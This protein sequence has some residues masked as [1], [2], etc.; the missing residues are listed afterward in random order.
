[1]GGVHLY[2]S[3]PMVHS[4]DRFVLRGGRQTITLGNPRGGIFVELVIRTTEV[5]DL[6]VHSIRMLS[7]QVLLNEARVAQFSSGDADFD[8]AWD[9]SLHT[10]ESGTDDAYSDCPWRERGTYI[11]DC[12]VNLHLHEQVSADFSLARR[13]FQMFGEGQHEDGELKGTLPSVVPAW[14]RDGHEDFTFIWVIGLRDYWTH[15]G[16][17]SL[18][19]EMWDRVLRLWESPAWLMNSKGLLDLS[20]GRHSRCF[21]DW[22][23]DGKQ[24]EGKS[25]LPAN[26]FRLEALKATAQMA[27]LLQ[28][29]DLAELYA[30]QAKAASETLLRVLWNE[31][32]GRFNQAENDASLPIHGNV[33][34]L[35]FGLGDC[36]RIL[37]FLE[38]HLRSNFERGIEDEKPYLELY[39]QSY[40]YPALAKMGRTDLA[41]LMISH[42]YG[43]LRSLDKPTLNE[44]F[45]RAHRGVGSCCHSWSGAAGVYIHRFI[46]G[47]RLVEAG[48]PNHLILD[49]KTTAIDSISAVLPRQDGEIRI[50]WKRNAEGIIEAKVEKPSSVTIEFADGVVDAG[51]LIDS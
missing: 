32:L 7:R 12:L 2:N 51:A 6:S 16:D 1:D 21:I 19:E 50:E 48:R 4:V 22:G 46:I 42:H 41:E 24:K 33:L 23:K 49:P 45:G 20:A 13:T 43:F 37:E 17:L 38:P 31:E 10:L 28:K 36:E 44:C 26:M 25:H 40:L 30:D 9:K 15:T 14:L 29:H 27:A 5:A 3:N 18:V 34:A 39:F 47:L 8:W 35:S 11:G